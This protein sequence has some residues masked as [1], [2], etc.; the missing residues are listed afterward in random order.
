M[1]IPKMVKIRQAFDARRITDIEGTVAEQLESLRLES[2]KGASIAIAAG[3]RGIANIDRIVKATILYIK[4]QGGRPFIV[5]AMGSHG[6]ATAEG[7]KQLL[8]GYGI[9]EELVGAPVRSSMQVVELPQ[10]DL[11][12]RVYMDKNAYEADAVIVINRIKIHT[13]FHGP[14]ESGLLKMCVIGLGK[15]KQALE[16]HKYGVYGLR[17]LIPETARQVLKS[18]KII[19]GIG[20]VENAYDETLLIKALKPSDFECEEKKL[21]DVCRANMPSLPVT[22][23]DILEVD[24]IG[25]NISG[26]GIDTNIIGRIRINSEKEPESP[27]IKNI[28]ISDI[29]E[30]S[31]GNAIGIGLGDFITRK[32]FEKID[33]KATYENVITSSFIERGKIPLIADNDR[34]ALEYALRLCRS[35]GTNDI[36][37]I[38]IRDSLHL[39]EMYVTCPVLDEIRDRADIEIVG[40][41]IDITDASGELISF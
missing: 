12:N 11:E 17:E 38:R 31:H 40:E 4:Q 27:D 7:Q 36:R 29:T 2:V 19:A 24:R 1:D 16:I 23:L 6:G 25:K 33:F 18:G 8:A 34:Q 14:T 26:T 39:G 10:D 5:P 21:L 41:F 35:V 15:H 20:I 13:D 37:M 3:S 32:L 22:S 28:V 9:T 30:E